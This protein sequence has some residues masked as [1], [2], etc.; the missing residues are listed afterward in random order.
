[1]KMTT[2]IERFHPVDRIIG[3]DSLV[4][5]LMVEVGWRKRVVLEGRGELARPL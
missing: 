1:M 5:L 2:I 4:E 3:L